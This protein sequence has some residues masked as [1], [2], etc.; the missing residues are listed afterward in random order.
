MKKW[1]RWM[2]GCLAGIAAFGSIPAAGLREARAAYKNMNDNEFISVEKITAAKTGQTANITFKFTNTGDYDLENV[3]IG[4]SNYDVDFLDDSETLESNFQFPFEITKGMFD[5]ENMKDLGTVKAGKSR[6]V[7]LSARVRR[8]I[9]EGYYCFPVRAF[10]DNFSMSDEYVNIWVSVAT[11]SDEEDEDTG[12]L[13]MILGE[14]QS[15]PDGTYPHVMNFSVNMRNASSFTAYDVVVSLE[16]SEDKTKYPFE[17]NDANYDRRFEKVDAGETVSLDYS[18]AIQKDTYSG[19]YPIKAQIQYRDNST[20]TGDYLKIE[21][22]F[23]VRI[24][25]KDKE[26]ELGEFNENDRTQARI[27][28]DSFETVPADIIAGQEFELILRMKNASSGIPA[29]NILFSLESEKVSDSAVFTTDTGSSSFTVDSLAPGEVKELRV[30]MKSR[31]GV[32]QR[33]YSLTINE[34]Y[35][36]PEFKNATNKVVVDIPVRQ[37]PRLSTGTIDV[38]P[39]NITV[40]SESN[41]M[42]PVNNT[43]RVTLYNVTARFEGDSIETSES[44]VGNIKPGETGNVDAMVRGA[45]PTMDDGKVK[46]IVSYEDED[47]LITVVEKEMTLF[48]TEDIPMDYESIDVGNMGGTEEVK[49]GF[50]SKYKVPVIIGAAALLIGGGIGL[51]ALK[52]KRRKKQLQAEEEEIDDEIS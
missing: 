42:F 43:G 8:D 47:G 1:K 20:H 29:S 16:M 52:K 35:D 34:T 33:S 38:M 51:S 15:T 41:V 45:A 46:I 48:V 25:N 19:Y 3:K 49:Q 9:K 5:D 6:N 26:D 28:V 27:I 31:S 18:M 4:F 39:D 2:I 23:Y 24:H 37:I 22:T 44:Y 40:G 32:D 17:I 12:D 7:T 14:G 30:M 13:D 36:S 50:F 10:G 21:R 11:S